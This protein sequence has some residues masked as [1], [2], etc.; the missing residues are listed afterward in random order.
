VSAPEPRTIARHRST[1]V[2]RRYP[3]VVGLLVTLASVP[4][5]AAVL[6]GSASLTESTRPRTPFVAGGPQDP[7]VVPGGGDATGPPVGIARPQSTPAPV[8]E[9][10]P[11]RPEDLPIRVV[12]EAD[13]PGPASVPGPAE[14]PG[15]V[16]APAGTPAPSPTTSP[17]PE[18]T[19]TPTSRPAGV[20]SSSGSPSTSPASSP[21]SAPAGSRPASAPAGSQPGSGPGSQP[22]SQDPGNGGGAG[23]IGVVGGLV[24]GILGH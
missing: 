22:G 3:M 24:G 10:R 16:P 17:L 21:A 23:L 18:C 8:S 12:R 11:L 2:A 9:N 4:T 13:M 7:V 14:V 19:P 1:G 5:L 6:A 20:P 15:T